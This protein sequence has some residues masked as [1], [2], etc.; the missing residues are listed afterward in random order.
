MQNISILGSTGSIGKQTLEVIA[1]NRDRFSVCALA[2]HHNDELLE[3][4]IN[5]FKP[6]IA[7]LTDEHAASRLIRRYRGSTQIL[8][9]ED[10]LL[11]AAV[12]PKANTV[13]TSLVGFAGLKPT[14]AA[15]NAGKNIALAN[16]ETLVAAGEIVTKTAQIKGVKILP[17]DSEHSAI[18]QCLQGEKKENVSRLILTASGGP[19]R[20][21]TPDQ[22]KNV[23]IA[24][25][26]RHPNWSMGKKITI[27]SATLANKGLEVIEARWLYDI[28]Y[29][30]IDVVVH[31]QSI[32]HS[33][34]EFI[35]GSVMAQLGMPDMRLPIQYALTYPE[36]IQADFAKV[37]FTKISS[38]SFESPNVISFPALEYAYIAGR[39][40]GSLP[41]VFNAANEAAVYA[42]LD[43][44]ISFLSIN[45]LIKAAMTSHDSIDSPSIDDLVYFDAWARRYVS[46]L[47]K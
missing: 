10:G 1:A 26:L 45:E 47:V 34:V 36:R 33:M 12:V 32:I 6:E 4:Q 21:M 24:D 3:E 30:K 46:G 43:G 29:D 16:K 8:A 5:I 22:L 44:K 37:D 35:D 13:V 2:A 23:E 31:P 7:V 17:V 15:I 19:F 28:G 27:D 18:L 25:C 42:F 40:G 14:M 20:G 39:T 38:L 41:C 11:E 9:G